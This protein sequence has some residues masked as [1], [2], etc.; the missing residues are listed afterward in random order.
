[1]RSAVRG[2]GA[3]GIYRGAPG[4][5]GT[6]SAPNAL[7]EDDLLEGKHTSLDGAEHTGVQVTMPI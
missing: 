1:M 2:A 5:L 3:R 7:L 6:R 4:L